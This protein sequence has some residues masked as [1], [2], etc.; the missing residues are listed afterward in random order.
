VGVGESSEIGL[1]SWR[2]DGFGLGEKDL[3]LVDDG[4]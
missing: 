4:A 3:L 2:V 1:V